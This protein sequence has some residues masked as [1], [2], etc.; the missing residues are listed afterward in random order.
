MGEQRNHQ[1][2]G[3]DEDAYLRPARAQPRTPYVPTKP[4][5]I[6]LVVTAVTLAVTYVAAP[7][8]WF[9]VVLSQMAFVGCTDTAR[10]CND[11]A[12]SVVLIAYPLVSGVIAV[13]GTCWVVARRRR[14]QPGS[15]AALGTLAGLLAAFVVAEF[16]TDVASGG[17][18]F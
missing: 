16:V 2:L 18:L 12:S 13:V 15:F 10:N 3:P 8:A 14:W 1:W 9:W 4:G 7:L 5:A 11:D 6:D 17:Y